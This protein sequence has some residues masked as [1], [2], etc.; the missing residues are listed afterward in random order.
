[1]ADKQLHAVVQ[2]LRR[3]VEPAGGL[4]DAELLGRWV[5]H[6]DQAA[7]EVLVWRHGPMVWNV[8]RRLLRDEGDAEDAF[9]ATFLTLVRR[10]GAINKRK[11]VG[12]WLYKVAYRAARAAQAAAARRCRRERPLWDQAAAD[13][14]DQAPGRELRP[15]LDAEI[16]RLPEKYRAP[17]VLC[18][19]QGLTNVEAARQL[20]CPTGTV[21]TRLAWGRERLR[22]RLA[23]RG[24]APVEY[25]LPVPLAH[26]TV[27]AGVLFGS[28][29]AAPARAVALAQGVLR[30]MSLPKVS[31]LSPSS[32]H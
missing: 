26:A 10:A 7:F 23:N 27:K 31:A 8:C 29:G 5:S 16:N 18:Y 24:L 4:R 17:L 28:G 11:A 20:G 32:T 21:A 22:R 6:R 1:M 3:A 9:Q 14:R 19:L 30:A 15:V 12:S 25:A 13:G 2:H